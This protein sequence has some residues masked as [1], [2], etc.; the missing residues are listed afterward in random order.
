MT[1][2]E[3]VVALTELLDKVLNT[4]GLKKYVIEDATQSNICELEEDFYHQIMMVILYPDEQLTDYIPELLED[5][6]VEGLSIT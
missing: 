6:T 2:A 4:L 3:K 1:D 5:V